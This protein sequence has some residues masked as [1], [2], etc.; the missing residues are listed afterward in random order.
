VRETRCVTGGSE[1]GAAAHFD[2]GL[3]AEADRIGHILAFDVDLCY[4]H[5]ARG[6]LPAT[7]LG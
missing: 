4:I 5:L 2:E 6:Q 3:R 7:L 1:I